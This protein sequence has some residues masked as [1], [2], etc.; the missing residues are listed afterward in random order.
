MVMFVGPLLRKV[1]DSGT[2]TVTP[3]VFPAKLIVF[4]TVPVSP[5][6]APSLV[7][8]DVPVLASI[9]LVL[10][11][12]LTSTTT[13]VPL[14]VDPH[15]P[16][17]A[18][19]IVVPVIVAVPAVHPV[20][21]YR[22]ATARPVWSDG[23][24]VGVASVTELSV[25]V[26]PVVKAHVYVTAEALIMLLLTVRLSLESVPVAAEAGG[27]VRAAAVPVARVAMAATASARRSRVVGRR[28]FIDFIDVCLSTAQ[29]P[30][31]E[32]L[33][34]AP[35]VRCIARSMGVVDR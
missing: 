9:V 14:A 19:V 31:P 8:T 10:V 27:A 25:A 32:R 1:S 3:V 11:S 21:P 16:V 35:R 12:P 13:G 28:N 17:R 30:G 2:I 6:P 23:V 7:A 20:I 15:V 22:P 5:P 24:P 29:R 34:N 26:E 33:V 18:T 4:S